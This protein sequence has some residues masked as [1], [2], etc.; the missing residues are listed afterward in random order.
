MCDCANK[1]R[2]GAASVETQVADGV[3]RRTFLVHS[4]LVAAAAA[5]AACGSA[6]M[7]NPPPIT[8]TTLK[9]SN[10]PTLANVGGVALMTLSGTPVAVVRLSSS[11]FVTVSR[12]CTHQ[13]VIVDPVSGGFHCSGHGATFDQSGKWTGGQQTSSLSTYPTSYNASA[14]TITIG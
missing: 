11:S 9:L 2:C 14:G 8:G 13:G 12:V 3:D 5:L 4:A 10:Y 6:G 1:G 7:T